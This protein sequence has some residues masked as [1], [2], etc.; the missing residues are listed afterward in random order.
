VGRQRE[1][2]GCK[3]VRVGAGYVPKWGIGKVV[4]LFGLIRSDSVIS[5][6]PQPRRETIFI[7]DT[8]FCSQNFVSAH[9]T[10]SLL[11]KLDLEKSLEQAS[12]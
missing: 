4:T 10:A 11:L 12:H 2:K 7:L 6:T 1:G 5:H 8:R 9:T 3:V